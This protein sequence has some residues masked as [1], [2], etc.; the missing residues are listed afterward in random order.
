MGPKTTEVWQ[1]L[2]VCMAL[3]LSYSTALFSWQL[4]ACAIV[5][6]CMHTRPYVRWHEHVC[7][8]MYGYV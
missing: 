1:A 7:P 5:S 2:I 8:A 6:M 3:T 4:T